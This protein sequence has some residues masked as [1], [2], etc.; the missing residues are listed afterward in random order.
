MKGPQPVTHVKWLLAGGLPDDHAVQVHFSLWLTGFKEWLFVSYR[1]GF[2]SLYVPVE[3]DRAI[4]AKIM[5]AVAD[6]NK[7]YDE[8]WARLVALNKGEPRQW[9][10]TPEERKEVED[11]WPR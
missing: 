5:I 6:F 8:Q 3:Y 9:Q 11:L 4:C 1:K 10:K 7:K 2:P